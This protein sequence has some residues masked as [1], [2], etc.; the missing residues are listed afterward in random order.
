MI[1]LLADEPSQP[2]QNLLN[3]LS[4]GIFQIYLEEK[5]EEHKYFIRTL[6]NPSLRGLFQKHVI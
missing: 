2:I 3:H 6:L 4:I 5:S 1:S